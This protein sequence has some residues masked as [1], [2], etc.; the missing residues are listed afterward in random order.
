MISIE[1]VR[2]TDPSNSHIVKYHQPQ[3]SIKFF[4]IDI[5]NPHHITADSQRDHNRN[6]THTLTKTFLHSDIQYRLILRFTCVGCH[7]LLGRETKKGTKMTSDCKPNRFWL[8]V[9]LSM[10][11]YCC[12]IILIFLFKR[13][14]HESC[15]PILSRM[16]EPVFLFDYASPSRFMTHERTRT[17][18]SMMNRCKA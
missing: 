11:F 6:T 1:R 18:A 7:A 3:H 13:H 10:C 4:R 8:V 9:L 15:A 17:D 5:R 14:E 16:L 12:A 2:L